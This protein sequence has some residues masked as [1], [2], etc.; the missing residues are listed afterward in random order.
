MWSTLGERY[1]LPIGIFTELPPPANAI[2]AGIVF[3]ELLPIQYAAHLEF[4]HS[5]DLFEEA[6]GDFQ[7]AF[8]GGHSHEK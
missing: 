3:V 8:S 5:Y 4:E 7:G 2:L 1:S 6:L